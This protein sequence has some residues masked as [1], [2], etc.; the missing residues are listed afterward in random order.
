MDTETAFV[1]GVEG[2]RSDSPQF[3]IQEFDVR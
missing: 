1:G 2:E 3:R